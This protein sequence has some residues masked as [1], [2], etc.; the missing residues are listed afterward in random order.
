MRIKRPRSRIMFS[1]AYLKNA[2][3]LHL[4]AAQMQDI[5]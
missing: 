2:V 4:S 1:D 3:V 5:T